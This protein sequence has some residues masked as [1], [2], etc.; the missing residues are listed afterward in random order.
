MP[1]SGNPAQLLSHEWPN[2]FTFTVPRS[3]HV[4]RGVSGPQSRGPLDHWR[5]DGAQYA[6][7]RRI[8]VLLALIA[9]L[10]VAVACGSSSEKTATPSAVPPTAPSATA[11][12]SAS[13]T[14]QATAQ[15]G[16][17]PPPVS[18]Q[19]TTTASGLK[20][21]EIKAGTGAQAQK[22]QTVS[23]NYTGWLADGTKFDSSL[24]RGQPIT[25]VLGSAQLIPG[26]VEG[27]TGMQVGEQRRL[28]IPPALG[29]GSQGRPPV[30]PANAEL[31]FDIELVSVK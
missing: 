22:G 8:L 17:G 28:I 26:F 6:T 31:T 29:Y 15:T 9:G 1:G 21:I 11:P 3:S 19:P 14:P 13:V 12:S 23:V 2:F 7:M 10:L 5:T 20:I 30:I 18:A 25:F 27:V 4:G 24:D 16:G